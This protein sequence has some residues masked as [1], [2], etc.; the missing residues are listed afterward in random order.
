MRK[1]KANTKLHY[2][3]LTEI[4][5]NTILHAE[6]LQEARKRQNKK[7]LRMQDTDT[8]YRVVNYWT[9][10]GVLED[11]RKNKDEWR[12]FS[13]LDLYWI[14]IIHTLRNYGVSLDTIKSVYKK[15]FQ[16]KDSFERGL[17]EM[18]IPECLEHKPMFFILFPDDNFGI[19]N[20]QE[21]VISEQMYNL[22]TY[23]K[24]NLNNI[25]Y[26][27]YKVEDKTIHF[28]PTLSLSNEELDLIEK[29][30]SGKF[31][32]ITVEASSKDTVLIKG[33]KNFDVKE[34]MV[35]ILKSAKYQD[36]EVKQENGKVS[37]IKQTVKTKV[38]E[39]TNSPKINKLSTLLNQSELR[40]YIKKQ[41]V[42]SKAKRLV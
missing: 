28:E 29:Y 23:I 27:L 7:H 34:R 21:L 37:N 16:E 19:V 3:D 36:L 13:I 31:E 20:F 6:N 1:I 25:V 26:H 11:S 38:K 8:A 12:K 32:S 10:Y 39:E 40:P 24:I 22:D 41:D 35:D 5:V 33:V 18:S 17:F 30:R 14:T 15:L 9:E 42:G 4:K 2:S